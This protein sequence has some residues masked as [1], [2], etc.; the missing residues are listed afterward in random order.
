MALSCATPTVD[1][2]EEIRLLI[3]QSSVLGI[4]KPRGIYS[5]ECDEFLDIVSFV[6]HTKG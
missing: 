6:I 2:M 1:P 5:D 3:I 4:S